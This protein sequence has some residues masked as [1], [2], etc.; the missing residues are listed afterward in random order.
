MKGNVST[1]D[2]QDAKARVEQAG[3]IRT[4]AVRRLR[5]AEE[6]VRG[7]TGDVEKADEE[8]K[9][10]NADLDQILRK[11]MSIAMRKG[12]S[13]LSL[14]MADLI[15][16]SLPQESGKDGRKSSESPDLLS[17]AAPSATES[18]PSPPEGR[19]GSVP[20]DTPPPGANAGD[21]VN[22]AEQAGSGRP[23]LLDD[24]A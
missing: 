4:N 9:A 23:T 16:R 11:V 13:D 8:L 17:G 15:A 21:L 2:L 24:A 6:A 22:A 7:A 10:A 18:D 12:G 5:R 19:A 1:K 3:Q 14:A 20:A